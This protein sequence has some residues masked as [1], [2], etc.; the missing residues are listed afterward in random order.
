MLQVGPLMPFFE[1]EL[2]ETYNIVR[3]PENA[4]SFLQERGKEF[5]VAV[6]SGKQGVNAELIAALPNLGAIINFGVGYDATDVEAAKA[7]GIVVSN[8]PDVLTD[9]VADLAIGLLIDTLRHLSASDR[10]VRRGDWLEG[11]YP[12]T[13]K[14][15]G[16]KVG[17]VGL[18]RIGRAI[19]TRLEG[20][21]CEISYN[22]RSKRADVPYAYCASVHEL[23]EHCDVV[24]V[25]ASGGAGSVGLIDADE[26]RALGPDGYLIN[27]ARGS[28]IDQDALVEALV[29]GGIAGA[30]LDVFT[31]EPHVPQELFGLDNVV[32]LPHLASGTVETR[33]AMAAL[34]LDNIAQF[35]A[36]GNLVTPIE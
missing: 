16:R 13:T 5:E 32:L 19:A 12:L 11:G 9:C 18:G 2:V 25:A 4:E 14:V 10:F 27:I 3:L 31:D 7:R 34:A 30:G 17:I 8:T 26:L 36:D 29:S 33:Q 24:I 22:N 21:G 28:V 20:F 23:A 35:I 15:S 6:T 1:S